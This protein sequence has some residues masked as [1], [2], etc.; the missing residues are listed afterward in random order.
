M[1]A[2]AFAGIAVSR[3][4]T[5]GRD[6]T[7]RADIGGRNTRSCI[8]LIC[9]R[10]AGGHMTQDR[11]AGARWDCRWIRRLTRPPTDSHASRQPDPRGD[12]Q[13]HRQRD[14]DHFKSRR[15]HVVVE[16]RV[17]CGRRSRSVQY[18]WRRI[19]YGRRNTSKLTASTRTCA[20]RVLRD[21]RGREAS[22]GRQRIRAPSSRG[23]QVVTRHPTHQTRAPES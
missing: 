11:G 6:G 4:D 23:R 17:E 20:R 10:Y 2:G 15:L 12:I 19:C 3:H 14:S 1:A 5:D 8:P 21:I 13:R 9:S 18:N 7:S 22:H 16:R